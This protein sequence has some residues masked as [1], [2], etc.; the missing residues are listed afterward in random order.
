M[1]KQISQTDTETITEVTT[2]EIDRALQNMRIYGGS[3]VRQLAILYY[4][5]D[6]GNQTI[7]L[8]VFGSYFHEYFNFEK[9]KK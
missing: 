8:Q 2:E 9:P 1:S 5:A 7:L 3:F 4:H 6:N